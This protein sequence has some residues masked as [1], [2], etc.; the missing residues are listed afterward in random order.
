MFAWLQTWAPLLPLLGGERAAMQALE[1]ID[2]A[3]RMW[4]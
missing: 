2:D 3:G 1:A 4:P